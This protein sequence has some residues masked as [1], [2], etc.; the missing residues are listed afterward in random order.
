MRRKPGFVTS[1]LR[2]VTRVPMFPLGTVL[3]PGGVLPLHVFEERYKRLSKYCVSNESPF[4]V[5]LIERGQEVGGGDERASIGCLAEII[6]YDQMS[7]GRANLVI[8]GTSRIYIEQ[9]HSDSPYPAASVRESEE[10]S[11]NSA[12]LEAQGLL[13]Q[14]KA[15][16][17]K[18]RLHGHQL[19]EFDEDAMVV[20]LTATEL[21]YRIAD[22]I[23]AGPF[24]R[25]R[26]LAAS[27]CAERLVLIGEHLQGLE[28]IL[29]AQGGQP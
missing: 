11:S 2:A 17:D 8:L 5:V 10:D 3:L 14:L 13:Q 23:P 21:I 27:G 24:D 22:L 9:W 18:A 28:E 7:D 12:M 25:Q 4:G 26:I 29:D 15:L 20:G 16:V 19:P 1:E 6:Q